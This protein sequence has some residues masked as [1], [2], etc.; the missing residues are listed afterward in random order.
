MSYI[1]RLQAGLR[2]AL[3]DPDT[4]FLGEDIQEPYGGA[5]KVSKGLSHDYPNQ[6]IATPMSEQG[7]TGMGIGMALGGL[8]VIVEIMFGDFITLCA[9]QLINHASKFVG[10]YD[11]HLH[12]V[13]RTPMGGYRGYG[14][15]HSQSIEKLFMGYPDLSIV[16]PSILNDPG[17]LLKQAINSGNPIVFIENKLDYTRYM[18]EET[19]AAKDLNISYSKSEFPCASVEIAEEPTSNYLIMTYGGLAA[20][21]INLQISLYMDEEISVHLVSP[22]LVYP[23]DQSLVDKAL[24]YKNIIIVEEGYS[25]ANWSSEVAKELLLRGYSGC[26]K[27][28]SAKLSTIGASEPLESATLP[29]MEDIKEY[30]LELENG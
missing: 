8:K 4:Y 1:S 25:G 13:L 20:D 3:N 26:L 2:E 21:L 16:A 18:M 10:L 19:E 28:Y 9:D 12:F 17:N 7:F 27:T 24:P 30:I 6:V 23:I 29:C 22:S 11:K 5:F 15:T 14:A